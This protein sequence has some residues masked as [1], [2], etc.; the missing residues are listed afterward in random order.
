M[1]LIARR[2][3]PVFLSCL[4]GKALAAGQFIDT[5]TQPAASALP[6]RSNDFGLSNSLI[7]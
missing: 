5:T 4:S 3:P 1:T 2:S 6:L 7:K